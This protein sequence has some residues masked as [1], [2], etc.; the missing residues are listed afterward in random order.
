MGLS[1]KM[2]K[3]GSTLKKITELHTSLESNIDNFYYRLGSIVA[4]YPIIVII[5]SLSLVVFCG[6]G[7]TFVDFKPSILQT[8]V[9]QNSPAIKNQEY[10]QESYGKIE[11][12][13]NIVVAKNEEENILTKEAL[14]SYIELHNRI[15]DIEIEYDGKNYKYEDICWKPHPLLGCGTQSLLTLWEFDYEQLSKD[16]NILETIANSNNEVDYTDI[17]GLPDLSDIMNISSAN[18]TEI[19]MGLDWDTIRSIVIDQLH[20][21]NYIETIGNASFNDGLLVHGSAL[22][23]AYALE[24]GEW[25]DDITNIWLKEYHDVVVKDIEYIT[26]YPF[27]YRA[28]TEEITSLIPVDAKL[29]GLSFIIML[30][31]VSATLGKL[32][33]RD[34]KILLGALGILS[35]SMSLLMGLGIAGVTVACAYSEMTICLPF[36]I[37]GIG[38]D[39]MYIIVHAFMRTNKKLPK[40]ERLAVALQEVGGAIT[41]TSVTDFLAFLVGAI[42]THLPAMRGFCVFAAIAVLCDFI[43]QVTFFCACV[44]LDESRREN[45]KLDCLFCFPLPSFWQY[46]YSTNKANGDEVENFIESSESEV[47]GV[48][49]DNSESCDIN[50]DETRNITGLHTFFEKYYAPFLLKKPVMAICLIFS[51]VLFVNGIYGISQ[52]EPS[53]TTSDLLPMHSYLKRFTELEESYFQ[54]WTYTVWIVFKT[55]DYSDID[56]QREMV[57][58]FDTLNNQTYLQ[59]PIKFWFMNFLEWSRSDPFWKGKMVDGFIDD[60]VNYYLALNQFLL[61]SEGIRFIP[62]IL[63]RNGAIKTSRL[64]ASYLASEVG[65]DISRAHMM[66]EMI[67]L[68]T[69][70]KI[71]VIPYSH[72]FVFWYQYVNLIPRNIQNFLAVGLSILLV[73][74]IFLGKL[75]LSAIVLFSI[76]MIDV[77]LLGIMYIW[78]ISL[79]NISLILLLLSIGLGVD[80]CAHISHAY[81]NNEGTPEERM[82]AALSKMGSSVFSGSLTSFVGILILAISTHR[83]LI[84]FFKFFFAMF[85]LA[86]Y[87]GLAVLPIVLTLFNK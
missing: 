62:D 55:Y 57:K 38:V 5:A 48:S 33:P 72:K 27:T 37:L 77:N 66:M 26:V 1:K 76:I 79:N 75:K 84:N 19:L 70:F 25:V 29:L 11:P 22:F 60:S 32:T 24:S 64:S 49:I 10:F 73:L 6:L 43:L 12:A 74:Y 59:E 28:E 45:G 71:P 58:V 65:N 34:S 39:D 86:M 50:M 20:L 18:I 15:L 61:S 9:P 56:S 47:F 67:E 87:N 31:Y 53:T 68:C 85:L 52:M 36:L 46:D 21:I 40:E 69:N 8:W 80:S 83:V 13:I 17:D 14:G 41:M 63:F 82:I 30:V 51:V 23:N 2:K 81:I 7:I 4:R 3:I 16:D 54:E 78:E 42:N 44:I 35:V